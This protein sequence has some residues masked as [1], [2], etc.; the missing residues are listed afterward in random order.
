MLLRSSVKATIAHVA[1][2]VLLGSDWNRDRYRY[3]S[4]SIH[5]GNNNNSYD[6]VDGF[7]NLGDGSLSHILRCG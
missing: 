1:E 6:N 2:S 4:N 3:R 7:N 5:D